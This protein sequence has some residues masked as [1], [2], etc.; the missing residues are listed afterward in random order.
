M[1][2]ISPW[3]SEQLLD[4]GEMPVGGCYEQ[5][6]LSTVTWLVWENPGDADNFFSLS[7]L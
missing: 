5:G 2:D 6:S 7:H 4:D 1:V 3:V